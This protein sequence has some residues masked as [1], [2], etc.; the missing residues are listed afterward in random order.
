MKRGIGLITVGIFLLIF[1]I[2]LFWDEKPIPVWM[3]WIL[4]W[5]VLFIPLGFGVI[6]LF[7]SRCPNCG[8]YF[9]LKE[10]GREKGYSYQLKC[11]KCGHGVWR[12]YDW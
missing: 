12:E 11:K 3:N 10:T 9:A 5:A 4:I 2:L 7:S 6:E 1:I 8:E